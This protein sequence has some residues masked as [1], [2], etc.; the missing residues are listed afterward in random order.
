MITSRISTYQYYQDG[1]NGILKNQSAMYAAM[2]EITTGKKN[3]MPI[4]D[5]VQVERANVQISRQAQYLRNNDNY[6]LP[7]LIGEFRFTYYMY[8]FIVPF[9]SQDKKEFLKDEEYDN[10]L[11]CFKQVTNIGEFNYVD[12]SEN[13]EKDLNFN[14]N[15]EQRKD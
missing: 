9:S 6:D 3:N 1:L 14:I 10:Y 13:E 5:K 4:Y 7:Y 8:V 11:K 15:F 2:N 12:F